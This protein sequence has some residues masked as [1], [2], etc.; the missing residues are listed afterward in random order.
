MDDA[1]KAASNGDFRSYASIQ[2][3]KEMADSGFWRLEAHGT[4]HVKGDKNCSILAVPRKDETLEAYKCPFPPHLLWKNFS[5]RKGWQAL[6]MYFN[7]L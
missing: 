1:Q 7:L 2:E 6:D 5:F 3:L 4:S